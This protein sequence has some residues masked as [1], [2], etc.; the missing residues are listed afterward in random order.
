MTLR[1]PDGKPCRPTGRLATFEP[2]T[3]EHDLFDRYDQEAIQIG[4]S[5]LLYYR[6]RVSGSKVDPLYN[7]IRD[8]IYD[9]EPYN[10]CGHWKPA[11]PMQGIELFGIDSPV[12]TMFFFN[13]VQFLSVVNEPP[14]SG[15]LLFSCVDR[16]A[17]E[18]IQTSTNIASDGD[19]FKWGRHR[20]LVIARNYQ[21]T[22]TEN[23]PFG[24]GTATNTQVPRTLGDDS[25]VRNG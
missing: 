6:L 21:P 14:T 9:I 18:I 22:A 20:F 10:V 1:R 25:P 13:R 3:T 17:W 12:D 19:R 7:E 24:L 15:S 4:S 8:K 23:D 16:I 11:T 2:A 5:P